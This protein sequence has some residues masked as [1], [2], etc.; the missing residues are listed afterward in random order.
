MLERET[1]LDRRAYDA[2]APEHR[3]GAVPLSNDARSLQFDL[4]RWII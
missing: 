2:P 1:R 4:M 3:S